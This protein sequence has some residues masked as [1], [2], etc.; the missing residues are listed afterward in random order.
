MIEVGAQ[1]VS[2]QTL[3]QGLRKASEEIEKLQSWQHEIIR[4]AALRSRYL[5]S[6]RM[7]RHCLTR[8]LKG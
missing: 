4:N 8:H 1:E 6:P 3:E 5:H 7:M 2:E